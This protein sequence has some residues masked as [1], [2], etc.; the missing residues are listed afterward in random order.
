[1]PDTQTDQERQS[2]AATADAGARGSTGP[3]DRHDPLAGLHK[4]STTAGV[5]SSDYVAINLPSIVATILGLAS[6]LVFMD[7]PV[8]LLIPILAIGMGVVALK[9][10]RESNGTQTGRGLAWAG[11]ALALLLGGIQIGRTVSERMAVRNDQEAIAR[12]IQA[13]GVHL[14]AADYRQ[15]YGMFSERF[16]NRVKADAFEKA[17][18]DITGNATLGVG[19]IKSVEWNRVPIIFQEEPESGTRVAVAMG[20]FHFRDA[21][22]AG[23]Q[24]IIFRNTGGGW[25]I[26][27]IPQVFPTETP[28]RGRRPGP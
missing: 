19:P 18:R 17:W 1:M 27:D 25:V 6:V 2:P 22:T 7:Q 23:R 21:P 28:G 20:L 16:Q 5:S 26:D 4:M 9:Q 13:L 10:I 3:A 15:A 8:L 24:R 11:I 12:Q 14:S